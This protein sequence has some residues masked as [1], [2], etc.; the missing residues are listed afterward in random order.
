MS[1]LM[2]MKSNLAIGAGV[3][4][5]PKPNTPVKQAGE[6][7][8]VNFFND[9]FATGFTPKF[10]VGPTKFAGGAAISSKGP[11][12]LVN[13]IADTHAKGFTNFM[14]VT[15]FKNIT[16]ES[17]QI[18]PSNGVFGDIVKFS[19]SVTKLK[20][21]STPL[22]KGKVRLPMGNSI[23]VEDQYNFRNDGDIRD[24]SDHGM[25]LPGFR[26]PFIIVNP[27]DGNLTKR[28]KRFDSRVLPIG[29][30]IQDAIRIGK[31][32]LSPKGLLFNITQAFLQKFNARPETRN[33]NP[34]GLLASIP[35]LIH[36][37]R[38]I[39]SG[40]DAITGIGN[41]IRYEDQNWIP[42]T[43]IG[44]DPNG[45]NNSLDPTQAEFNRLVQ[46]RK[47]Q[48]L[49]KNIFTIGS[50]PALRNFPN[51]PERTLAKDAVSGI[52]NN[53]VRDPQMASMEGL[54]EKVEKKNGPIDIANTTFQAKQ[55]LSGIDR[56]SN[57][58]PVQANSEERQHKLRRYQDIQA[59]ASNVAKEGYEAVMKASPKTKTREI[60]WGM[61]EGDRINKFGVLTAQD[62]EGNLT[63]DEEKN[64]TDLIPFRF[65]FDAKEGGE[66]KTKVIIFRAILAGITDTF[67]AQYNQTQ[68]IG[69]PDKVYSYT[70]GERKIGMTF[71][72]MPMAA[73]EI[74]PIYQ[75]LNQLS[76]LCYPDF[77]DVTDGSSIVGSRMVAPFV[78]MTV[79]DMYYRQFVILNNVTTTFADGTTWDI[80]E[81]QKLP[82]DITV[83]LD[84]TYI[85][86]ELPTINTKFYDYAD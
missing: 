3:H 59:I 52:R 16:R 84:F 20:S 21:N 48:Y 70:G 33:F 82:R 71:R 75:K 31:F 60:S 24:D 37:A 73:D 80:D 29:S 69:R 36:G 5:Y 2:T 47:F 81:G 43:I 40:L 64:A 46:I 25:S 7:S 78:R 12:G 72:L 39:N 55:S 10:N 62:A 79:G 68:Y 17:S 19:D 9:T 45:F 14:K 30:T 34:L 56:G 67:T 26:Q 23:S 18:V 13:N 1:K 50:G 22:A 86:N 83:N 32:T 44:D 76:A 4:A 53:F 54:I 41:P 49:S 35:P 61:V 27:G 38:H 63:E 8:F 66:I 42:N 15:Q 6:T 51:F 77:E 85:G 58:N 65:V 57:K 74:K 11:L 28:L